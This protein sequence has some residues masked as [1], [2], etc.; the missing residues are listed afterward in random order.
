MLCQ[1][2]KFWDSH[3]GE[4]KLG[5]CRRCAPPAASI[6]PLDPKGNLDAVWPRTPPDAWC[7]EWVAKD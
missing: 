4:L 6:S 3:E 5:F 1:D 2:C 7:G